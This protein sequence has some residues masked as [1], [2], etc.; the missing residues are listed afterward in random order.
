MTDYWWKYVKAAEK[1]WKE[2]DPDLLS[3][4]FEHDT[5][6][7][8]RDHK[9]FL[10]HY[11]FAEEIL[12]KLWWFLKAIYELFF[13]SLRKKILTFIVVIWSIW[14]A[15]YNLTISTWSKIIWNFEKDSEYWTW[16]NSQTWDQNIKESQN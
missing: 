9:K 3:M 4:I 1:R 6:N 11:K 13:D 15:I 2:V 16:V 7:K 10:R 14:I 8:N 5:S 12:D